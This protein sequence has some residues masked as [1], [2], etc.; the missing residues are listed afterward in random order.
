[1]T[2]NIHRV[3]TQLHN[4][5]H[6]HNTITQTLSNG[7]FSQIT[8]LQS[9]GNIGTSKRTSFTYTQYVNRIVNVGS[10]KSPPMLANDQQ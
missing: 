5:T 10:N 4:Y 3:T 9:T 7:Q 8:P 2:V 6:A 1:M